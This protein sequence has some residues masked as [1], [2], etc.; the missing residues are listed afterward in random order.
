MTLIKLKNDRFG[1]PRMFNEMVEDFFNH[2]VPTF[3]RS[4]PATNVSETKEKFS[5]EIAA[6]GMNK[7]K[8]KINVEGNLLTV[9]GENEVNEQKENYT[10]KEFSF[11][12]F[13]RTF[14]LPENIDS[15]NITAEYING[16]LNVNIPKKVEVKE[17]NTHTIKIS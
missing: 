3:N 10:R 5:L 7:E 9:S 6:P 2:E 4:T 1:A 15:V 17:N 16:I 8:M 11:N 12:S 14:T 13:K